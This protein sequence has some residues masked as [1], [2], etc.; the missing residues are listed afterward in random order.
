MVF[1]SP[2]R[3]KGR[4]RQEGVNY[5]GEKL[6]KSRCLVVEGVCARGH[7]GRD[8]AVTSGTT[9]HQGCGVATRTQWVGARDAAELPA[10]SEQPPGIEE[11]PGTEAQ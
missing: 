10:V 6:L 3:R 9:S 5:M 11:L 8:C 2:Q 4:Q 1:R 7:G